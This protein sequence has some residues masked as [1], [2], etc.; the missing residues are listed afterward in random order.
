MPHDTI[1][2]LQ[3]MICKSF[4]QG[5][6][7]AY[8][9]DLVRS[10][11]YVPSFPYRFDGLYAVT[12]WRKDKMFHKEVIE[13]STANGQTL[14]TPPMDI[15]PVTSSVLFRWHKHAFPPDLE[16]KED[17]L[18]HI[19]VSLDWKVNFESYLMIEKRP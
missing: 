4:E 10:N 3:F 11:L 12:C 8:K 18:L 5:E 16:I 19:R 17:G 1:Q 7:D 6:Q 9:A 13:Y 14:K 15:E 2:L